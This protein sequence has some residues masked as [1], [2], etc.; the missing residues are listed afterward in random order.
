MAGT[1]ATTCTVHVDAF[2]LQPISLSITAD[3]TWSPYFQGTIVFA[4]LFS[5]TLRA[6]IDP[7]T[8]PTVRVQYT[9]YDADGVS[10]P[11]VVL[12][13][14]LLVRSYDVDPIAGTTT[15]KVSSKEV[16]LQDVRNATNADIVFGNQTTN[17]IIAYALGQVGE[18]PA[19]ATGPGA[20]TSPATT[21]QAGQD[22]WS[23]L[24]GMLRGANLI[25]WQSAS[26][27]SGAWQC[28]AADNPGRW[29]GN[30]NVVQGANLVRANYGFDIEK[31]YADS[32]VATYQW[33]VAGAQQKKVYA[34]KG[35]TVRR[36]KAVSYNT[37]DPGYDPS[38][39][40]RSVA[41]GRGLYMTLD[42]LADQQI[43]TGWT[44]TATLD[45]GTYYGPAR[46]LTWNYPQ[47]TISID[48][49]NPVKQGGLGT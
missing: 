46:R 42:M 6:A 21:L 34:S 15:L 19:L 9:K 38:P 48:I 36:T 39:S 33:T 40:L 49:L 25:L 18:S 16:K 28:T 31:D 23:W 20:F 1:F 10:N 43:N 11:V 41:S 5:E 45:S 3:E 30:F 35:A 4:Q 7:R 24:D 32:A 22:L 37:P 12:D 2:D 44:C 29:A 13:A 8:W 14:T 17:Q 27:L 26:W 47:D